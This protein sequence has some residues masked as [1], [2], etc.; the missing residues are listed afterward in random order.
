MSVVIIGAGAAGIFAAIT[1]KALNP[2]LEVLVL[3]KT[4]KP[5][6]KVKISGG[7]RCNVTHFCFD[8]AK[9]ILNYP[10]GSKE[11]LGPFHRFGPKD[12]VN[13]FESHGV[14]LK[15]EKDGRMF[16]TTDSS[17]TIID[18][19]LHEIDRLG[20]VLK[21]ETNVTNVE[22]TAQGYR[23]HIDNAPTIDCEKLVI[24]TGS[25][26]LVFTWLAHL[27]H[28]IAPPVPSLFTFNIES[29]CLKELSG[30]SVNQATVKILDTNLSQTG[31]LLITHWGF[32][33]P[34]VLKLS[35]WGARI[36][37]DRDYKANIQ[38]SWLSGYTEQT[39]LEKIR[40]TKITHAK[41]LCANEC[42][43]ELPSSLW[44]ALLLRSGITE[45]WADISKKQELALIS[46]LLHDH[47]TINGQTTNKEEFVTCGGISLDEIQFKSMQ[48][49]LAA[50]LF[51]AGEVLNIDGV[52]GGFNF[53]NAWTTG[54]IAGSYIATT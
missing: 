7:G 32:S 43:F 18:C 27:G 23:I 49:K 17:Q 19:L 1:I 13:W 28:T 33:G 26:R 11:L 8:P 54:Y 10:R 34:A 46:H 15:T 6:A 5:L 50:N 41:R 45:R 29:F 25:S 37:H 4:R 9:L 35:A 38:I 39:L 47:F 42:P 40:N 31:P 22:K 24:A 36:L 52:T 20:V 48:S 51:F 3:E 44:K 16:P 14:P 2:L 30:I 21:T 12:T 53:Q